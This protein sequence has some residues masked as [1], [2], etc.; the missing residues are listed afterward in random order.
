MKTRLFIVGILMSLSVF[1]K[2]QSFEGVVVYQNTYISK[3]PQ[4]TDGQLTAMM[5][6]KQEYF[7]KGGNYKSV[8]NGTFVQMQLYRQSDNK[9]YMKMGNENAL[10]WTD[11]SVNKD[12]VTEFKILKNQEEILGV[13][14]DALVLTSKDNKMTVYFNARHKIDPVLFK[15][16]AF[17][18]WNFIIE[19]TKA[20]PLKTLLENAQFRLTSIATEIKSTKVD[21]KIFDLPADVPTKPS[22]Y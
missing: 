15:G 18:N 14:C 20:V 7:M 3:V 10:Y 1:A 11:V 2:A 8:F 21:D 9:M 17:G 13:M 4:L 12:E 16:H 22:P 19:K 6:T 5:G